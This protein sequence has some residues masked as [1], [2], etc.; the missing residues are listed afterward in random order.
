M[1]ELMADSPINKEWLEWYGDAWRVYE[2]YLKQKEVLEKRI[3]NVSGVNYSNVRVTNGSS[4]FLSEEEKYILRLEK[5]NRLIKECEDI[6]LPA[7]NRLKQQISRIHKSE[8]RKV[9]ILR[10]IERWKWVDII[11]E[12]FWYEE[13]LNYNFEKYK[14]KIMYWNKAAL[15]RL[16]EI[17]ERPYIPAHEQIKIGLEQ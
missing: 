17:S 14:T 13:D 4:Q 12:C 16:E 10:Y 5:I 9:L 2:D 7:K 15:E 11:N 3:N 8:Y 1:T 6:L